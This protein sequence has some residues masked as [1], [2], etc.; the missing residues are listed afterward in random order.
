VHGRAGDAAACAARCRRL[1]VDVPSGAR[2]LRLQA[3]E[4]D[5]AAV[6]RALDGLRERLPR[7]SLT[8]RD[9]GEIVVVCSSAE[10][11]VLGTDLAWLAEAAELTGGAGEPA[12]GAEALSESYEQ[13]G[14]ALRLGRGLRG[15]GSVHRYAD[16]EAY[17]ALLTDDERAARVRARTIDRLPAELVTTLALYLEHNHS[18]AR[19]ASDL[20]VHRNTVHYRL[21][22]IEALC[23]VDLTRVE[24]RMLCQIALLSARMGDPAGGVV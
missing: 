10:Q 20:F 14:R 2:V 16:V 15:G 4:A 21:R 7:R 8:A 9:G 3:A 11:E 19:T 5:P 24:D 18:V 13:A 6:E 17:D 1:G 23:D 22:R 12:A